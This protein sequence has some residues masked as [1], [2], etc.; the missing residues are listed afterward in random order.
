MDDNFEVA[1]RTR[2]R[3]RKSFSIETPSY[4]ANVL[5]LEKNIV[6]SNKVHYY[7]KNV[8]VQT[9][10]TEWA[11]SFAD[12]PANRVK[13]RSGNNLIP[14]QGPTLIFQAPF[15]ILEFHVEEGPLRWGYIGSTI[16]CPIEINGCRIVSQNDVKNLFNQKHVLEMLMALKAGQIVIQEKN[17]SA[18]SEKLKECLDNNYTENLNI[19]DF[20]KKLKISR[21]VMTRSF[22]LTYGI[23][24]V[25][26]RTKLR[27]FRALAFMREGLSITEASYLVGFSNP[28]LFIRSFK[29]HLNATPHQYKSKIHL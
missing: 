23:S 3:K 16:K 27:L 8:Y 7:Q 1:H 26:Y 15:S 29:K 10:G 24:P 20:A 22:S 6:F 11:I 4:V 18:V 17:K 25:E 21:V 13:L 28:S 19:A 2:A 12:L 5:F 14:L 9:Y